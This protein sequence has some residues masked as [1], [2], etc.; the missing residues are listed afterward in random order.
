LRPI[1]KMVRKLELAG[2]VWNKVLLTA[3]TSREEANGR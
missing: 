1:T 2:R 3:L